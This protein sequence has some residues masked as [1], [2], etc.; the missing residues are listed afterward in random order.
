MSEAVG[1]LGPGH[2]AEQMQQCAA[3]EWQVDECLAM[4]GDDLDLC[5]E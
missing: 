1:E 4:A 5:E 3:L 2:F